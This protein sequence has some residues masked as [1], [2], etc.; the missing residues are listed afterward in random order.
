MAIPKNKFF[1]AGIICAVII[2]TASYLAYAGTFSLL[3]LRFSNALYGHDQPSDK[4]TIVQIDDKS[5]SKENGLGPYETWNRGYFAKVIDTINKYDPKVVAT[6]IYFR[7]PKDAATDSELKDSLA[8][9]KDAVIGFFSEPAYLA[10]G[11]FAQSPGQGIVLPLADFSELANVKSSSLKILKSSDETVRKLL[12]GLEDTQKKIFYP[13]FAFQIAHDYM[14]PGNNTQ[15]KMPESAD[16]YHLTPEVSVPLKNGEMLIK[17]FSSLWAPPKKFQSESFANVYYGKFNNSPEDLFKDKIVLIGATF[18]D[19]QD[20]YPTP[21][22]SDYLMPGVEIHANAIQT[23]LDQRFLR[24]MTLPEELMLIF[25]LC[26]LSVFVFM[27]TKIRWSAVYLAGMVTAYYFAAQPI[28]NSG[29]IV[30]LVHP[31]LVLAASF[32]AVYVYR[33]MTEFRA[34]SA[35]KNAF[36]RYVNPQIAAQIADHPEEIKL[37]GEKKPVTVLFTDIAHFTSISEKLKAESLVALLNEYLEAMTQ[38]IQAE[39]GTVDKYEGDAIMA[40]FGAPLAQSDHAARACGAALK[41]RIRLNELLKKWEAD[42]PLPGGEKKPMIDFRCGISSGEVIVGNI[43]SK[44]KIEYTVIGDVVNLGSRL[45]GQNKEYDT[46]IV[47]SEATWESVKDRFEGRELDTIKVVGK[48]RPIK[49]YEV[50][51][52]KG[53]LVPAAAALITLYGD[54]MRLYHERKF[55]EALAKFEEILK[56]YSGDGPSKIYRQRCEVFRDFPPPPDWDGVFEK[57]RK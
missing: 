22:S 18:K 28:F 52:F 27:F 51:N 9:T 50:L 6:D 25:V 46:R 33:Y 40:F 55:A 21:T 15:L 47:A 17:Y 11:Y 10:Q 53:Q 37:G 36:S 42:S 24:N 49:I 1:A 43:G 38:V 7:D 30:D 44:E 26:A 14:D 3:Q 4:I 34:K 48:S 41:M 12:T 31:Y 57:R 29:L 19:S 56:Q 8:K 45:E 54:G 39:G 32:I 2:L 5:V 13:T 23:I 16:F 20:L 35:L